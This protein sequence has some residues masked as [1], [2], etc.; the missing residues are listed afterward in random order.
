[1]LTST[2]C[3]K[4][5]VDELLASVF[6]PLDWEIYALVDEPLI[7]EDI[8]VAALFIDQNGL[9]ESRNC[10]RSLP[11]IP[12]IAVVDRTANVEKAAKEILS[13]QLAFTV[14]ATLV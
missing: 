8:T 14:N 3:E 2:K 4:H 6:Q 13:T 11:E 1:M 10:I 7:R 12:S 5:A 9:T